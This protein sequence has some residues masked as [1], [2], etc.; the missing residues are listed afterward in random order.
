MKKLLIGITTVLVVL[1]ATVLIAPT[2]INW[3]QYRDEICAQARDALG[4]ELEI[5]GDIKITVLPSPALVINDV[6]LAN[7]EGASSAD[8]V[9][10]KSLEVHVALAPLLGRIIQVT[11]IRLVEPVIKLEVLEDGAN[12]M[13]FGTEAASG[14]PAGA[15]AI[16]RISVLSGAKYFA[17][18]DEVQRKGFGRT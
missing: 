17:K 2:F 8:M 12:N 10:L 4:R 6:H 5:R 18:A 15:H 14:K 11:S 3:N 1:V 16:R 7:V 13:T 9:T